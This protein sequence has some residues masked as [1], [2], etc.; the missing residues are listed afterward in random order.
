MR[1]AVDIMGGDKAPREIVAGCV[2]APALGLTFS[3]EQGKG[4]FEN[5]RPIHV[6]DCTELDHAVCGTGF[7]CL[8]AR[9]ENNNLPVLSRI[10][11]R[12]RSVLRTGSAAFA[13]QRNELTPNSKIAIFFMH[14]IISYRP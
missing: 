7:S 10:A 12:L 1:I 9:R 8:R 3:A 11:P 14:A 5:G 4:A 13:G 6:S 2:D